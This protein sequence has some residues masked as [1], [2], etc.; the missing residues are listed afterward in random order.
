MRPPLRKKLLLSAA[1]LLALATILFGA[2]LLY[3]EYL[4]FRE[5]GFTV[6]LLRR[7]LVQLSTGAALALRAR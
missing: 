1:V 4:W 5:L 6:V 7:L 2:S 3:T